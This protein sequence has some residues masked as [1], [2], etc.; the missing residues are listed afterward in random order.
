MPNQTLCRTPLQKCGRVQ[1]RSGWHKARATRWVSKGG[2]AH[3]NPRTWGAGGKAACSQ[4]LYGESACTELCLQPPLSSTAPPG[5]GRAA[6]RCGQEVNCRSW[7]LPARLDWTYHG[8]RHKTGTQ[9]CS[10]GWESRPWFPMPSWSKKG[11]H[12][13]RRWRCSPA[14]LRPWQVQCYT[15]SSSSTQLL[16]TPARC[17]ETTSKRCL[18]VDGLPSK[19]NPFGALYT[20]H[21]LPLQGVPAL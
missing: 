18:I 12:A 13:Q 6:L 20:S 14:L 4:G 9:I 21:F 8:G 10:A 16:P 7:S 11:M 1:C 2:F 15:E 17:S 19:P 5:T 3:E